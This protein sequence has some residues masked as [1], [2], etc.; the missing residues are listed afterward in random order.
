MISTRQS[1]NFVM[2]V[3]ESE[4]LKHTHQIL[5]GWNARWYIDI[6]A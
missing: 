3:C 2:Q 1:A 4:L 5:V 6:F